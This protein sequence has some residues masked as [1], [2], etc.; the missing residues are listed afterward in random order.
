MRGGLA[1]PRLQNINGEK[2]WG[3]VGSATVWSRVF[4]P[5]SRVVQQDR[6][7]AEVVGEDVGDDDDGGAFAGEFLFQQLVADAFDGFLDAGG[8]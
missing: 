2:G 1:V 8:E 5:R 7:G 4:Q 6:V 3:Q